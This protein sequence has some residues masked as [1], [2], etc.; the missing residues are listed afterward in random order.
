MTLLPEDY[1][2]DID[3][4]SSE[5]DIFLDVPFVPTDEATVDAMLELA[6]AG[7][8]DILYDLGSGDGRIVIA[9]ARDRNTRGIGIEVDP[10]QV[11]DA[12][13]YAGWSGVE[14]LVDFIEDDL[15]TVD[16]SEA[17]IVTLYL[18]QSVNMRLRSRFLDELRP[19]TR[20]ISHDFDM[21][22]WRPDDLRRMAG[23][24]IYKWIVPAHVAGT[25]EWVTS[26]GSRY[27]IELWQEFQEVGGK[28]WKD[29]EALSLEEAT[30]DGNRLY[31]EAGEEASGESFV[32]SFL[33]GQVHSVDERG[34][35]DPEAS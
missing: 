2:D 35:E 32:L 12:M 24:T 8:D 17:T 1:L 13:E 9:A 34:R 11:A 16:I 21:G 29:N 14:Q 30:L 23:V 7:P 19:G 5:T 28:V 10:A 18:L 6:N 25:H 33:N 27:R 31:L 22:D 4:Y 20:I 26:D 15:F 3:N